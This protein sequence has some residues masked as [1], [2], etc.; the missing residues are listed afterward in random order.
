[1]TGTEPA[2]AGAAGPA[3]PAGPTDQAQPAG[4]QRERTRL[5]WQRT[6][7]AATAISL[8]AARL[9]VGSRFTAA[10][11]PWLAAGALLW[12]TVIAICR[13]RITALSAPRQ[14]GASRSPAVLAGV[15]IG[16]AILG[17]LLVGLRRR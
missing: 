14:V 10:T 6:A 13:R 5:A 17:A 4:Q 9:A 2:P 11:V 15:V 1:V 7:L 16:Y 8:L 12:L 3:R